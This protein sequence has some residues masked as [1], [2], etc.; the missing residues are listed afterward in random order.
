MKSIGIPNNSF[1]VL[2]GLIAS[3][4]GNAILFQPIMTQMIEEG[5]KINPSYDR[6][7]VTK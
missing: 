6:N 4:I 7:L 5:V 3:A 2:I 1:V